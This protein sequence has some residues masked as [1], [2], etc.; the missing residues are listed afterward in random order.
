MISDDKS[1]WDSLLPTG[2]MSACYGKIKWRSWFAFVG[3][4]KLINAQI[5]ELVSQLELEGWSVCRS[6]KF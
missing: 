5:F 6:D 2:G 4:I 1:E 3:I